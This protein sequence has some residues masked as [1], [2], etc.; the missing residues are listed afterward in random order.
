[1]KKFALIL[2]CL[3]APYIAVAEANPSMTKIEYRYISPQIPPNSFGA[4]STILYIAG[5]SYSRSEEQPDPEQGIHGLIV[6][7][8]PDVWMINLFD[9]TG[10]HIVDPGPT[11]ITHHNI[12][13]LDAPKEFMSLEF[14]KELSFFHN[15]NTTKLKE[16]LLDGQLCEGLEFKYQ[17]YR[18][19]LFV[20]KVTQK[21]FQLDIFKNGENI[22]AIKYISYG[23]NLP[24]QATLFHPPANIKITEAKH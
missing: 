7:S 14:G 13:R 19:V 10:Q 1:M 24:F 23:T 8:G 5:T 6:T 18:L 15:H 20:Q 3:L 22:F 21:P 2:F 4:K 16:Q 9:K 11:F 17:D 12:M